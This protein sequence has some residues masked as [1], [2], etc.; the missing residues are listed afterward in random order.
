M[1]K[2]A[3]GCAYEHL[4]SLDVIGQEPHQTDGE[5]RYLTVSLAEETVY[6]RAAAQTLLLAECV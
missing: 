4:Y 6:L 2:I 5:N 1:V 3:L